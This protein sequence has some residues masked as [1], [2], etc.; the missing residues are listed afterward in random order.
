MEN[1]MKIMER[2]AKKKPVKIVVCEGNDKR[3][4]QASAEILKKDLA[5]IILL[6]NPNEINKKA[7]EFDADVSDAEIID[8][9]NYDKKDELIDK[10]VKLREHKGMTK[11]KAAKLIEDEN[12]FGCMYAVCGYADAAAGSA[13]CP[14]AALMRP[15]LQLLRKKDGLVSEVAI[16]N[17]KKNNRYLFGADFS[18]NI[19]PNSEQ[20]AQI[21]ENAVNCVKRFDI[22]PKVAMLSYST[23]GSGGD[24]ED[25]QEIRNAVSLAKEKLPD[26]VID[27]EL[28]VDAAVDSWAAQRK[29][30]DSLL[31]GEANILIFPNLMASNIFAHSMMQFSDMTLDLTIIEGLQKPVAILGRST[32]VESIRNMIIGCA[33]QVNTF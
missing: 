8:Y 10:L 6:G 12:Y 18:M 26:L 25:L 21:T 3:C 32:P 9:K 23:K 27:G 15:V 7:Q 20:L 24:G 16:L 29:C 4:L 19:N 22:K 5:K 2:K 13:V 17:D 33:M 30:P 28:Q 11:E 31:K 1:L 14:T